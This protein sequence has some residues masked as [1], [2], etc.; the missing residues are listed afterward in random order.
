MG[1]LTVAAA[2]F[3]ADGRYEVVAVAP[4][5]SAYADLLGGSFQCVETS[6]VGNVYLAE[7]ELPIFT[8]PAPNR[9]AQDWLRA[10]G[11]GNREV[12][13]TVLITGPR[14]VDGWDT[15]APALWARPQPRR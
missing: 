10:A 15:D 9:P 1:G 6:A 11:F 7:P 2:L 8:E 5:H 4:D 3:Q 14:D 13:G 12:V